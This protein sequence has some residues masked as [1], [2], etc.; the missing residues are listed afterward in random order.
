MK[1]NIRLTDQAPARISADLLAAIVFK[2]PSLFNEKPLQRFVR[3]SRAGFAA[4]RFK[5]EKIHALSGYHARHL[6]MVYGE[7]F[8]GLSAGERISAAVAACMAYTERQGYGSI[9]ILLDTA[10]E[11]QFERAYFGASLGAYNFDKYKAKKRNHEVTL[12]F[13]VDARVLSAR[14]QL[15]TRLAVTAQCVNECRD[16]VNEP[17]NIATTTAMATRAR[18]VARASGLA[19]TELT[20]PQLKKKGLNGHLFVGSGAASKPR[21]VILSYKPKKNASKHL[22]LVGKGIVFDS[23]GLCIKPAQGMW[24]MKGDMAGA[25]AVLS[26]LKAV[27]LLKPAIAVTGILCLAENMPDGASGRPGDI[28]IAANGKSVHVENT[29]A[30]GRLVLSDGLYMAGKLGATHIVDAATLTGACMVALGEKVAGV[31]GTSDS[32]V[33]ALLEASEKSG[34]S[35][36]KLPLYPEYKEMLKIHCA[37]INN[38]TGSRYG[39]AITGGL[40]LSEFAPEGIPWAHCD[41]AGPVF[42]E[43]RWKYYAEGATGFGVRLFLKLIELL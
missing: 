32:L 22:C 7:A 3:E 43:K 10:D 9:A 5:G 23:G 4:E 16:L 19:C 24:L 18:A 35:L 41:I 42:T 12:A 17:A 29:D 31:M 1:I 36:W 11:K 37:D 20:K 13:Q 2:K 21:M 30:E 25:A 27:A 40:F 33:N 15:M 28:F 8:G 34:E 26:T 38:I 14:G 39:G 6:L